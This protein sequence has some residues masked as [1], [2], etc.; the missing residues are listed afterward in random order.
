VTSEALPRPLIADGIVTIDPRERAL[1][2]RPA[3]SAR[4]YAKVLWAEGVRAQAEAFRRGGGPRTVWA[5]G[6][7]SS[8]IAY[9]LPE[10]ADALAFRFGIGDPVYRRLVSTPGLFARIAVDRASD[11]ILGVT[12]KGR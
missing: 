4:P 11:Q 6:G 10:G 7:G 5:S 3:P 1:V 2:V 9:G 12:F 8:R